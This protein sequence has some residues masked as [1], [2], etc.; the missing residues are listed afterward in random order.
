MAT[1]GRVKRKSPPDDSDII[2][3]NL[4]ISFQDGHRLFFKVN[5]DL[6][7]I[8]VFREFCDRRNLDYDTLKFIYEGTQV[9]GNQTPKTLNMED[10]AEIFAAR[11]Q[12]GG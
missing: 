2:H 4:S 6:Q 8:K 5:Q 3:V 1:N 9:R 11:H 12:F 10:G 7:L